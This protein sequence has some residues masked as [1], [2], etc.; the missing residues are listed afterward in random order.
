MAQTARS[1][2]EVASF[3]SIHVPGRTKGG[4][5]S[6][7]MTARSACS[8]SSSAADGGVRLGWVLPG[9]PT[10]TVRTT[11]VSWNE[12]RSPEAWARKL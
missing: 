3:R 1:P 7:K 9:A 5:V 4:K 6:V 12:S 10:I 11:A 8:A 2:D